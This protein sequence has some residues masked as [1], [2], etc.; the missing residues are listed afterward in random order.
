VAFFIFQAKPVDIPR[1]HKIEIFSEPDVLEKGQI[2]A[3]QIKIKEIEGFE[4][5]STFITGMKEWIA[6]Y[7]VKYEDLRKENLSVFE[8]EFAYRFKMFLLSN[9]TT[10]HWH[11]FLSKKMAYV[12]SRQHNYPETNSVI[13]LSLDFPEY[14]NLK[15]K[16]SLLVFQRRTVH[17]I[18]FMTME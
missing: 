15:H 10:C 17:E 13:S 14:S 7:F 3:Q 5:D 4:E 16:P 8:K 9:W 1:I 6:C 2:L 11:F 18:D 12:L